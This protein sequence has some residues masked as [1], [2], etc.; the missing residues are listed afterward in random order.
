MPNQPVPWI[1][2]VFREYIRTLKSDATSVFAFA[3][4]VREAIR[5][6]LLKKKSMATLLAALRERNWIVVEHELR[7]CIGQ[8][9]Q[10]L[11]EEILSAT[12]SK[13]SLE[14]KALIICGLRLLAAQAHCF[15]EMSPSIRR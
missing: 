9:I 7:S 6:P 12:A 5:H 8:L 2:P 10:T 4:A 3:S 13:A 14:E 15:R 1:H 11:P